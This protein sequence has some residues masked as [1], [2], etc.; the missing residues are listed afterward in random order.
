MRK[1]FRFICLTLV[2]AICLSMGSFFT[3]KETG[4]VFEANSSSS[5]DVLGSSEY[6]GNTVL[7]TAAQKNIY[8]SLVDCLKDIPDE[9]LAVKMTVQVSVENVTLG[10]GE[11]FQSYID[12]LDLPKIANAV[13]A[14]H[15]EFFWF[16]S[17]Q[18]SA[19]KVGSTVY[20]PFIID[21]SSI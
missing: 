15:P 3:A 19:K 5:A 6:Y 2:I 9:Q 1:S 12:S 20:L 17:F 7:E 10:A 11:T 4:S 21:C 8:G 18:V 13:W 14:D 16:Y